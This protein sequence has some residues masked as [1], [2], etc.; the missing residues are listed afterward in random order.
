MPSHSLAAALERNILRGLRE[1]SAIV[2][3]PMFLRHNYMII[4]CKNNNNNNKRAMRN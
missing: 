4:C 1:H 3:S 2:P